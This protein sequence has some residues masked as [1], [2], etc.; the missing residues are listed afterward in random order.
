[1]GLTR[2]VK[3]FRMHWGAKVMTEASQDHDKATSSTPT[4]K[5]PRSDAEYEN[6]SGISQHQ[7]KKKILAIASKEQ[8][9]PHHK[10]WYV[11]DVILQQYNINPVPLVPLVTP[12][13]DKKHPQSCEKAHQV[14]PETPH[15]MTTGKKGVKRK[16]EGM[17][18]VKALFEAL[19]SP[20][21]SKRAR[22]NT[23]VDQHIPG[24]SDSEAFGPPRKKTCCESASISKP[25]ITSS[26]L[27][28]V[29]RP[30]HS[31]ERTDRSST[32]ENTTPPTSPSVVLPDD[33]PALPS[34][35]TP[36]V[37]TSGLLQETRPVLECIKTQQSHRCGVKGNAPTKE[38]QIDWQALAS[39]VNANAGVIISADIH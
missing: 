19:K 12:H 18:S 27:A 32:K 14:S 34:L 30:D 25:P 24:L 2:L 29:T 4:P 20:P 10:L 16:A 8:R 13:S 15:S 22:L 5:T 9:Q 36:N 21:D 37:P 11:H 31:L 7:L 6:A 17:Q 33:Q 26:D 39:N 23:A 35:V 3:S 38:E 1:M 28:C